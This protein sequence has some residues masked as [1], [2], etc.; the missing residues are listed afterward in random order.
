M[1]R[2]HSLVVDKKTLPDCLRVTATTKDGTIM[3]LEHKKH[4]VFGVQFHPESFQSLDGEIILKN[5]L[6][7]GGLLNA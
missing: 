2:Y 7:I 6:K 3:G 1:M 5:F 4:N